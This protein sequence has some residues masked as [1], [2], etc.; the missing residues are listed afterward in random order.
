MAVD[1]QARAQSIT[2]GP[3]RVLVDAPVRGETERTHQGNPYA[4]MP[5]GERF[6]IADA[7][8]GTHPITLLL[9]WPARAESGR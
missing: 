5:D 8:G 9:N 1:V 3:A 2:S 4:V 7:I 6:L